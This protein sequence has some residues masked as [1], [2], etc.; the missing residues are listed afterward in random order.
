MVE[1][2]IGTRF[3]NPGLRFT[4]SRSLDQFQP[5]ELSGR[6]YYWH[7]T[8]Q[9]WD[10]LWISHNFP[11]NGIFYIKP[12]LIL[13]LPVQ[14]R[15]KDVCRLLSW[16]PPKSGWWFPGPTGIFPS[17]RINSPVLFLSCVSNRFVF[18]NCTSRSG[19]GRGGCSGP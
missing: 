18:R 7:R 2:V 16:P 14:F 9:Q 17:A 4:E 19:T 10:F 1:I 6:K 12:K 15:P 13:K 11:K 5:V 8:S 3:C